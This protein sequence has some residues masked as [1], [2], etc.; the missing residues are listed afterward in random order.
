MEPP[1]KRLP[2]ESECPAALAT[3]QGVRNSKQAKRKTKL[4]NIKTKDSRRHPAVP[5]D[6]IGVNTI[7]DSLSPTQIVPI[8]KPVSTKRKRTAPSNKPSNISKRKPGNIIPF[9]TEIQSRTLLTRPNVPA[10]ADRLPVVGSVRTPGELLVL[11]NF[12]TSPTSKVQSPNADG[13][14]IPSSPLVAQHEESTSLSLQESE[15]ETNSNEEFPPTTS[16]RY[17]YLTQLARKLCEKPNSFTK[18][19]VNKKRAQTNSLSSIRKLKRAEIKPRVRRVRVGVKKDTQFGPVMVKPVLTK[20]VKLPLLTNKRFNRPLP[21]IPFETRGRS[22]SPETDD[23]EVERDLRRLRILS[24]VKK[25]YSNFYTSIYPQIQPRG[26]ALRLPL[27]GN[28]DYAR[29]HQTAQLSLKDTLI[30]ARQERRT[31]ACHECSQCFET[32]YQ[33]LQ[34]SMLAKCDEIDSRYPEY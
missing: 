22:T 7:E 1:S 3:T 29:P 9:L 6:Q 31:F 28:T 4:K 27:R 15:T 21:E 33:L 25:R 8:S 2:S 34:H 30:F 17:K 24:T 11:S 16:N 14:H 10:C 12:S 18:S 5:S 13:I 23:S 26:A 32:P 19:K 20:K